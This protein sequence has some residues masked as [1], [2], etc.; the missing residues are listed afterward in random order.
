MDMLPFLKTYI[1]AV[2]NKPPDSRS[3]EK[4][5][6]AM[7]GKMLAAKLGFMQSVAMQ[8]EPYLT[9]YQSNKPLIPFLYQDLYSMSRNL[10]IRFVKSDC[11]D[12]S[13]HG[14]NFN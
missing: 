2:A 10:M 9:K 11:D 8:L 12:T 6:E 5:K 14:Y 4:V 1:A 3:F 13:R 7:N